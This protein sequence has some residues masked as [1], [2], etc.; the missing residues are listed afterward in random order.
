MRCI[1]PAVVTA[2][3]QPHPTTPFLGSSTVE[4]AAVNRKVRGSNP[5]RG[6]FSNHR[7]QAATPFAPGFLLLFLLLILALLAPI[8]DLWQTRS[9]RT[10][11]LFMRSLPHIYPSI[12]TLA[13]AVLYNRTDPVLSRSGVPLRQ[14]RRLVTSSPALSAF[15]SPRPPIISSFPLHTLRSRRGCNLP[16]YAHSASG[17]R[18]KAWAMS[19]DASSRQ[20]WGNMQWSYK[21]ATATLLCYGECVGRAAM[22][23]P[24][25]NKPVHRMRS[26]TSSNASLLDSWHTRL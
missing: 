25:A 4:Q 13:R 20:L 3:H 19:R 23:G 2:R 26:N 10:H 22:G 8:H 16:A 14:R 9:A 5:L 24:A 18:R 1:L 12:P 15:F 6:A 7:T 17:V 21:V 11:R